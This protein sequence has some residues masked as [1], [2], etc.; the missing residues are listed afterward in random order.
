MFYL[1]RAMMKSII[2][3]KKKKQPF[4]YETAEA[5]TIDDTGDGAFNNSY[6]FSAHSKDS[7]ESLYTRLGLRDDGSAEVWV[8]YNKGEKQYFL[9]PMLFTAQTSP[10]KVFLDDNI[11]AFSFE[12]ELL[13]EKGAKYNA[14]LNCTFTAHGGAVDFFYHMPSVRVATA[15]AQDKW[16]KEYFAGISENNSVHYEQEG[17]LTGELTLNG[18]SIPI[19]L[20]CLRDH[21]YGRRVW[22]Y[23]NNHLWLAAVDNDCTFNFSMVSYPSMSILEVGHLRE[24]SAPVEYVVKADYD[25]NVIATGETPKHIQLELTTNEKRKVSVQADLLHAKTYVFAN[26]DYTFVEG[27]ADITVDGIACRG[28]LEVGFNRDETRFMNGKKVD[29]IKA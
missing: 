23:M 6:Y 27:I 8:F 14:K 11:W 3:K 22:G 10:L 16:T 20:P 12:G 17:R 25:R 1:K 15:M 2:N 5:F 26:G 13:D 28:I 9:E 7:E 24:K 21:S 19:D 18:K 29:K 4:D